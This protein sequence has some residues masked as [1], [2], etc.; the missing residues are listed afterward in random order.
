MSSYIG[1]GE[2][3]PVVYMIELCE[4]NGRHGGVASA[5]MVRK[6]LD[7][8]MVMMWYD[9]YGFIYKMGRAKIL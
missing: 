4:C 1:E 2:D 6:M 8:C 9:L 7:S 3:L 5:A